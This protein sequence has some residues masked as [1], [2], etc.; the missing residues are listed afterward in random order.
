MLEAKMRRKAERRPW[1]C[2]VWIPK[3]ADLKIEI[4]PAFAQCGIPLQGALVQG[5]YEIQ[6]LIGKNRATVTLSA[7]D[8][9][10]GHSV[11]V[12]ALL[13]R[14]ASVEERESFLQDAEQAM[15]LS[16]RIQ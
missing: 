8:R 9:H 6:Q 3:I 5:R 11:T 1:G 7:L 14:Q 13:P 12:R 15:S 4:R 10:E 2:C 16:S